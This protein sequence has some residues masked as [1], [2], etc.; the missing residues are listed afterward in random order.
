MGLAKEFIILYTELKE[1][2]SPHVLS[3]LGHV[4]VRAR[5]QACALHHTHTHSE[6]APAGL[7]VQNS[8]PG[9]IPGASLRLHLPLR[10]TNIVATLWPLPS[11]S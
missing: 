9:E 7:L 8:G 5:T 1:E 11:S 2:T 3:R 6:H 4:C 10:L